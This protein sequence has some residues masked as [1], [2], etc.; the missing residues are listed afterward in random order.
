MNQ[1]AG[2]TPA[3]RAWLFTV[4][5]LLG[6]CSTG[7]GPVG[8]QGDPNGAGGDVS[9]CDQEGGESRLDDPACAH[10]AWVAPMRA[11][12]DDGEPCKEPIP[13]YSDGKVIDMVCPAQIAEQRLTVVDL[14]DEWLPRVLRGDGRTTVP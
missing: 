8:S 3:P 11:A 14:G 2:A 4:A 13:R 7:G 5:V 12:S 6:S 10:G 1:R 9:S